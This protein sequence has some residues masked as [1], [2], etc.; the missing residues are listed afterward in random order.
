MS[1]R[2]IRWKAG[3]VAVLIGAAGMAGC[4]KSEEP[5]SPADAKAVEAMLARADMVDGKADKVV[6]KCAACALGM[7]GSKDNSFTISGYTMCFCSAGCK[8]EFEK[9]PSKAIMAIKIPGDK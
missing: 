1:R 7:D 8:E 6:S 3:T 4:K 9:A 2:R 5:L